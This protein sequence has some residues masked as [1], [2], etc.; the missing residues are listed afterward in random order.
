MN[1]VI[2]IM[3]IFLTA[4]MLFTACKKDEMPYKPGP[5]PFDVSVKDGGTDIPGAADTV[6]LN[7]QAGSN[8]W[9]IVIPEEKQNWCKT[10][11]AKIY[12]TGDLVLPLIFKA[13]T[14]GEER[15]VTIDF[16]SSYGQP[17]V[18]LT[19]YQAK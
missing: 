4:G 7:I 16:N 11:N 5:S 2:V 18:S 14:S 6:N 10:L 1:R 13:N 9:W 3:T 15:S 12:G 19:F 8:G 17:K